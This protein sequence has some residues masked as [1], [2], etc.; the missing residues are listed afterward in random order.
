[1]K[2]VVFHGIGDIRLEEVPEPKIEEPTD[3]IV[4][5]TTSA[6]CGTDLHFIRGTF[7]GMQTGTILG[8]EGVGIIEELGAD[9]RNLSVG[10]RVVIPS[11]IACGYCSYCRAGYYAQCDNA[12]PNGKTAGTAFF[13]G[14]PAAGSFHG[15]QA[16]KARIP[17]ANVGLVKLPPQV[18]DE[19]AILLS[20][21]FPTGYFGAELAEIEDGDTV[22][23]FGCG[24][25]GQFAIASAK[26]MGAGRIFAV[27]REPSRLEMARTQGA[28]VINFDEEHP[29]ETIQRL[30]GGIGVDRAIDAVGVDAVAAHEGPAA[31]EAAQNKEQFDEQLS[32]VAPQTN[33]QGENWIPGDAPSQALMWALEALCKAGTLS[34][35]GVYP[36]EMQSF[37]IGKAMNK[38]LTIKMGNCHH[39]KYI[40]MLVDMVKAGEI[41]PVGILTQT[42]PMTNVIDAYKAFDTRQPGWVKVEL[43]PE[44]S[45]KEA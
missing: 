34:I 17:F 42:V 12:N 26:L 18:S 5:L 25:V 37:P 38:N 30:T 22:A 13:G 2:A 20:D 44:A 10:D 11:T 7:S 45:Q 33:P 39:R 24:P 43:K 40:P 35:I 1:M 16:E 41:D 14:P 19:Q 23:V 15:L 36:P 9:V 32:Q 8:H 27:D 3:A 31:E 29:V 4:R 21:I 28:E 6:I